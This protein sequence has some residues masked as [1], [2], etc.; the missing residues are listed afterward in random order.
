MLGVIR[1]IRRCIMQWEDTG[2][3]AGR[4]SIM[5]CFPEENFLLEVGGWGESK[6]VFIFILLSVK[7]CMLFSEEI[8][9][10]DYWSLP[11]PPISFLVNYW[12]ESIKIYFPQ[13]WS[14]INR[15]NVIFWNAVGLLSVRITSVWHRFTN[16][17]QLH[18]YLLTYK[19]AGCAC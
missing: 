17:Q 4:S 19:W 10:L 5:T 6:W 7:Y 13:L 18:S 8:S 3:Q 11:P 14:F 9:A 16:C 12:G 1:G 15:C 2:G